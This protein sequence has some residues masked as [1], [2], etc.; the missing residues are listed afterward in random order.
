MHVI[1]SI[2]LACSQFVSA[3][4]SQPATTQPS[5]GGRGQPT[6]A[7]STYEPAVLRLA[8]ASC[9]EVASMLSQIFPGCTSYPVEQSNSVVFTGPADTLAMARK[10]VEQ[11]DVMAAERDGPRVV[12][13]DVKHR[14]VE[15]IV[16]H[17]NRVVENRRLRVSGDRGRSKILLRGDSKEITQAESLLKELDTPAAGI[18]IDFAF[19]QAKFEGQPRGTHMPADLDEVATELERFGNVALLGRLSTVAVEGEKFAVEGQVVP[20]IVAEVRGMVSNV[21]KEGVVKADLKASVRLV[22][23]GADGNAPGPAGYFNIETVVT[24]QRGGYLVL[25]SAPAGAEVGESAILV[26]HVRK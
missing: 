22:P 25:G 11:M 6:A 21:N 15:E 8:N 1:L 4:P 14:R 18:A 16:D 3:L 19:I 2:V 23:G 24:T 20:G 9:F 7:R 13:V 26:M 12:I 10:L 5:R 17:L